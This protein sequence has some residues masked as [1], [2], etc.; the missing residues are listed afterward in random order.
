MSVAYTGTSAGIFGKAEAEF[1]K[2]KTSGESSLGKDAFL[3]L[4]VTQMKYQDPLNPT[5]DKEF[6]AQLAQFS[7][8]EQL[9]NLN[10]GVEKLNTAQA[11]QDMIGAVSFIGKDVKAKGDSLS[12]AGDKISTLYFN[13]S[14]A[15]AKVT[16]NVFDE[17]GNIIKTEDLGTKAAG[18]QTYQWDGKDWNGNKMSDGIYHVGVGAETADGRP[19]LTNLKVTGTITGMANVNGQYLLSTS[20]GRQVFF[21]DI[22]EVVNP[23]STAS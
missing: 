11:R 6:L 22:E 1:Q 8:L 3:T 7:S 23:V 15:A 9:T 2:P 18:A 10:S 21:T 5:S 20:D 4:L 14:E 16:V 13:L 17:N 12:K 19:I